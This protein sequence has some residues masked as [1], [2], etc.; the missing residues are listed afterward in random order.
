MDDG[1]AQSNEDELYTLT[2]FPHLLILCSCFVIVQILF[3]LKRTKQLFYIHKLSLF[4]QCE[5]RNIN[6]VCLDSHPE[7]HHH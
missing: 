5:N 4:Y 2:T 7:Q 6:I 1:D 3:F